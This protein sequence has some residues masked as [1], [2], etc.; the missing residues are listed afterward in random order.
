MRTTLREGSICITLGA[1]DEPLGARV[2]EARE[3]QPV[4]E[5]GAHGHELDGRR[6]GGRLPLEGAEERDVRGHVGIAEEAQAGGGGHHLLE[7]LH[8][9]HG[10]L[11][12]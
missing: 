9:P 7:D 2:H 8:L 6:G 5:I 4:I 3:G 1:T 10:E 11:R 12:T